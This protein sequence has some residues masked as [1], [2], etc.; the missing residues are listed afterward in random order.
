ME[1]EGNAVLHAFRSLANWESWS[2]RNP[3]PKALEGKAEG[4]RDHT[5]GHQ[6][7][8]GAWSQEGTWSEDQRNQSSVSRSVWEGRSVPVPG[9]A[10]TKTGVTPSNSRKSRSQGRGAE[11][12]GIKG[13][14]RASFCHPE[15]KN[16]S[17]SSCS[18]QR[19]GEVQR[20]PTR[21]CAHT[22]VS[23]SACVPGI[24][25]TAAWKLDQCSQPVT[26][27]Q[28]DSGRE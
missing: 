13:T 7:G 12:G 18:H 26:L 8:Q 11:R 28:A 19:P 20:G 14:V 9:R 15:N 24:P 6:S 2:L 25:R 10:C 21:S 27:L 22:H 1:G 4:T 3:G 16:A 5:T 17:S 23:P